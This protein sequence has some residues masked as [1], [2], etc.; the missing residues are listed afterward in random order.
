VVLGRYVPQFW[1]LHILL[2]DEPAL[3]EEARL[4]QRLLAMDDQ[5]AR[6]VIDRYLSGHSLV[7]LCDSVIVPALTLAE[8]DRHK[9]AL[10][11]VREEFLFLSVKEILTEL[12]EKVEK[13]ARG[14]VALASEAEPAALGAPGGRILCIPASDEADEVTAAML[15]LL[16][17]RSGCIVVTSAPDASLQQLAFVQPGTDDVFC[18]SALPPFAFAHARALSQQLRVHFPGIRIVVGVWG[19]AG[20]TVRAMERFQAPRPDTLVTTMADAIQAVL[21][22]DHVGGLSVSRPVAN[23]MRDPQAL[24]GRQ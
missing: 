15:A 6:T 4:Y 7:Q 20:D 11:P 14:N 9:G 1:F 10:A 19:F 21:T 22:A 16:L 5:E 8:H 24:P 12:A 13:P 23:P 18:I 3:L 17:E 2:G